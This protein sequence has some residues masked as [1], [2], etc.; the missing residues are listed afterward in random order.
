MTAK[1]WNDVAVVIGIMTVFIATQMDLRSSWERDN[2]F[3]ICLY[4]SGIALIL[5]G[6]LVALFT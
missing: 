4:L 5:G 3:V 2:I 1:H 6:A